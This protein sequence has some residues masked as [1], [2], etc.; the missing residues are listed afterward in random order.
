MSIKLILADDHPLTRAGLMA[1]LAKEPDFD[2]I[3]E[4]A[5]GEAAWEGIKALQPNVALLDIRMP[6]MDGV[7]ITRKIK[8]EGIPVISLMLTSY[9][10]QQYVLSSLRA[11]ARGYVNYQIGRASCRE[12]V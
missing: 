2:V 4:Y 3:G 10:A 7:S 5:D 12:R 11:G 1:Y 6:G 8:T 9:D